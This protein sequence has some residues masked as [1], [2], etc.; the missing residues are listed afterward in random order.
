MDEPV[1]LELTLTF[2]AIVPP[3]EI[4][5]AAFDRFFGTVPALLPEIGER[6]AALEERVIEAARTTTVEMV[7]MSATGIAMGYGGEVLRR[8]VLREMAYSQ[9]VREDEQRIA[10]ARA[11]SLLMSHLTPRQRDVWQR[12]G[13]VLVEVANPTSPEYDGLYYIHRVY[14]TDRFVQGKR[15]HTYCL[16]AARHDLDYHYLGVVPAADTVLAEM[17][18][19]RYHPE[20][21]HAQAN[22]LWSA[23]IEGRMFGTA[24]VGMAQEVENVVEA[25]ANL[26]RAIAEIFSDRAL[27]LVEHGQ[28]LAATWANLDALALAWILEQMEVY[29]AGRG[30]PTPIIRL[31]TP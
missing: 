5:F 26:V 17:L 23:E 24:S 7:D 19:L 18:L 13:Y 22:V 30:P 15:T 2:D 3:I 25:L 12:S 8:T 6:V 1:D 28:R 4:D 10:A 20:A 31:E 9:Y 21:Y 11:E 29:W 14:K 16:Q 27:V